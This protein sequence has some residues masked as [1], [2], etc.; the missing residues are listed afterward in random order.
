VPALTA[1]SRA[2]I[3]SVFVLLIDRCR[4]EEESDRSLA[5]ASALA[6]FFRHVGFTRNTPLFERCP[7][8]NAKDRKVFKFTKGSRKVSAEFAVASCPL[9]AVDCTVP[10]SGLRAVSW[11]RN[12]LLCA[13]AF[14][15]LW[16]TRDN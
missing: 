8:F 15:L 6:S 3:I 2:L 5:L 12:S 16:L 10:R 9:G 4:Q 14:F 7:T 1:V 11:L 13:V